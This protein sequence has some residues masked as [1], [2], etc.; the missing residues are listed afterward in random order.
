VQQCHTVLQVCQEEYIGMAE[1]ASLLLHHRTLMNSLDTFL[2]SQNPNIVIRQVNNFSQPITNWSGPFDPSK[3]QEGTFLLWPIDE[4]DG[5]EQSIQLR[6][7]PCSGTPIVMYIFM[8][9]VTHVQCMHKGCCCVT[10]LRAG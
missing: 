10:L 8:H 1:K 2:P 3:V 4:S 5:E 6:C 9:K 7:R